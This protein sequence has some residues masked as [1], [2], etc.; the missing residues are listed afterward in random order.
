MMMYDYNSMGLG[1]GNWGGSLFV[2]TW[3]VWLGVGVLLFVFL[4]QKIKK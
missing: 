3:L 1:F 4:W 2:L